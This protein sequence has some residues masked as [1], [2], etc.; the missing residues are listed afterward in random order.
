M[1]KQSS[2]SSS[3]L[4]KFNSLPDELK[5]QALDF[6]DR[7]FKKSEQEKKKGKR[8]FGTA[9]GKIIIKHGFDDPLDEFKDYM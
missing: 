1:E 9:K 8:K 3:L 7:L 2:L 6:L 5:R 4:S